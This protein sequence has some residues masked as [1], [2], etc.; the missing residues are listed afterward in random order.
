MADGS[1][2]LVIFQDIVAA[3]VDFSGIFG[4]RELPH[5][6]RRFESVE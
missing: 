4:R 6:V 3:V 5:R 2:L 1:V